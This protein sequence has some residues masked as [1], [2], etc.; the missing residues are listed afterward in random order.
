MIMTHQEMIAVIQADAEH[1]TIQF[2][3]PKSREWID[4][5]QPCS[6]NF[7]TWAYRAKPEV[8]LRP[9][10]VS[11]YPHGVVFRRKG[12]PYVHVPLG[13]G[14]REI[15]MDGTDWSIVDLAQGWEWA[16]GHH[17]RWKDCTI[18]V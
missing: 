15:R 6:F 12:S 18:P 1:K 13:F 8:T 14:E 9:R 16:E 5:A 2:L 10:K 11:E 4:C 3:E 7:G 17:G